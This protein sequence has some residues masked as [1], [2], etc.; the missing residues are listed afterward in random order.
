MNIHVFMTQ[1]TQNVVHIDALG[2]YILDF[3]RIEKVEFLE[4]DP[5][6]LLQILFETTYICLVLY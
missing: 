3:F 1:L 4:T 2:N 6:L 5:V